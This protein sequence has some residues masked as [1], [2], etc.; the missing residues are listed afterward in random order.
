VYK[1]SKFQAVCHSGK[2]MVNYYE[3]VPFE[4]KRIVVGQRL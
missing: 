4:K 1:G 2:R 3:S